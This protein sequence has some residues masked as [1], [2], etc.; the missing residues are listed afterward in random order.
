[1]TLPKTI[2]DLNCPCNG[3]Y[4]CDLH[5]IPTIHISPSSDYTQKILKEVQKSYAKQNYN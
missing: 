2:E 5:E 3:I 4:K 1:M